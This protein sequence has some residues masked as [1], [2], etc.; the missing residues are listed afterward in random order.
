MDPKYTRDKRS[1]DLLQCA[2]AATFRA[3]VGIAERMPEALLH[4]PPDTDLVFETPEEFL[5]HH[6]KVSVEVANRFLAEYP[7]ARLLRAE[8]AK[9][10]VQV[11]KVQSGQ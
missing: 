7:P 6:G 5:A 9:R 10:E 2:G 3:N 11:L 8:L 4:L 1:L